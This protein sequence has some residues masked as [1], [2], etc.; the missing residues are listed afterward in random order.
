MTLLPSHSPPPPSPVLQLVSERFASLLGHRRSLL[1]QRWLFG[2]A[3][4][5][6]TKQLPH[7]VTWALSLLFALETPAG[8]SREGERN[9]ESSVFLPDMIPIHIDTT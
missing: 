2:I 9:Q 8:I 1:S 4:E 7:N 6:V 3:D 5:F